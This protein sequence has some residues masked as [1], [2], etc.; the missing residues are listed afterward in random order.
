MRQD[1]FQRELRPA[2]AVE[3]GRPLRQFPVAHDVEIVAVDEGTVHENGD[4]FLLRHRQHRVAGLRLQQRVVHLD[5]VDDAHVHQLHHGLVELELVPRRADVTG[6]A[7]FL[8]PQV[9]FGLRQDFLEIVGQ[10]EVEYVLALRGTH[11][12]ELG[13]HGLVLHG[14]EIGPDEQ[15]R[16]QIVC[17]HDACDRE[18]ARA[19]RV[20]VAAT[21]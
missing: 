3:L 15:L 11:T 6:Q 13:G 4:A 1:E 10:N 14:A 2:L 18:S 21:V 20:D 8:E 16:L 12:F 7:R 17:L 5:E 19:Q 9:P